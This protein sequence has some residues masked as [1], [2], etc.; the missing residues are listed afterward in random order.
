MK[1]LAVILTILQALSLTEAACKK[2]ACYKAVASSGPALSIRQADCKA[3]LKTVVDD[4]KTTTLTR[5][6]TAV[7][8]VTVTNEVFPTTTLVPV[9]G[10]RRRSVS[11]PD[12]PEITAAPEF[13]SVEES[14]LVPRDQI[15]VFWKKACLRWSLCEYSESRNCL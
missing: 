6:V 7:T 5:R 14:L 12:P 2:D 13:L 11:S 1:L 9:P 8:A 10:K 4:D 3:A 15:I